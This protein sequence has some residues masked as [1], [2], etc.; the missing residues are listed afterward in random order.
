MPSGRLS[1]VESLTGR[2]EM[3]VKLKYFAS[4]AEYV[5]KKGEEIEL[6]GG[7]TIDDLLVAVKSQ[8]D[9]LLGM[10]SII[11]AVNGEYNEGSTPLNE[12]D[13]VALFPPV[14]GG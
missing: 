10:E 8:H 12:G 14:S 11:V 1:P 6:S 2:S 7:T 3:K 5:G 9:A 13:V 4:I